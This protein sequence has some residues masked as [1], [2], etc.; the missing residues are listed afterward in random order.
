MLG[1]THLA[2]RLQVLF[3]HGSQC[4]VDGLRISRLNLNLSMLR[5]FAFCRT[6]FFQNKFVLG[7]FR[8]SFG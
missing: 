5:D 7:V 2:V 3:V 1:P 4:D 8:I 6:V